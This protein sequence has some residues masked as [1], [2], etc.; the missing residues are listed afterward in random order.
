MKLN[1][2]KSVS[3]KSSSEIFVQLL[4]FLFITVL[5]F[6]F[7]FFLSSLFLSS[8]Y[9]SLFPLSSSPSFLFFVFLLM[10]SLFFLLF[11]LFFFPSSSFSSFTF[12][13]SLS[14]FFYF[15]ATHFTSKESR[16]AEWSHLLF[17]FRAKLHNFRTVTKR[18][19]FRKAQ[20]QC[21][22]SLSSE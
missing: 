12:S 5:F 17:T 15:F 9:F 4:S 11:F 22:C 10:L 2:V 14:F 1:N 7:H 13:L 21:P 6:S 19:I 3:V 16:M 8:F 18:Q 20:I